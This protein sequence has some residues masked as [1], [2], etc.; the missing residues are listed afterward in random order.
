MHTKTM[1]AAISIPLLAL[2]CGDTQELDLGEVGV[3]GES[4]SDYAGDWEGYSE[5]YAFDDGSDQIRIAL[6][7]AGNGVIEVGDSDPLPEPDSTV[8]FPPT[9]AD[10]DSS[11]HINGNLIPGFSYPITAAVVEDRR[12][13]FKALSAE[14][15]GPWCEGMEPVLDEQHLATHGE[16]LYNCISNESGMRSAEG[17][18]S[19]GDELVDCGLLNCHLVCSCDADGC[20]LYGDQPDITFDGALEDDGTKLVG[21]LVMSERLTVRLTR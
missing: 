12:I 11:Q 3:V 10:E 1:L 20:G 5:A 19:V 8:G 6:D 14:P 15:F 16:A 17:L 4:L 13:R 7:E 9:P 2:G 18:C 21:T